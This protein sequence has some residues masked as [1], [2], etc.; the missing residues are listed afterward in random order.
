LDDAAHLPT[1]LYRGFD[2]I[3]AEQI[4]RNLGLHYIIIYNAHKQTGLHAGLLR[5][6]RNAGVH[7]KAWDTLAGGGIEIYGILKFAQQ[8]TTFIAVQ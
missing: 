3:A 5:D 8:K 1:L 4:R 6:L 2:Q 7:L